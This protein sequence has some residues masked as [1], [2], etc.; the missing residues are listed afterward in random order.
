M[1]HDAAE[2][3]QRAYIAA[4]LDGQADQLDRATESMRSELDHLLTSWSSTAAQQVA[5]HE[6]RIRQMQEDNLAWLRNRAADDG[7]EGAR[8]DVRQVPQD[9]SSLGAPVPPGAG[10]AGPPTDPW[11][12]ELA[13][14]E[15]IRTMPMQ[16]WAE[17]R[18]TLIRTSDGLFG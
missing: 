15:R 11:A 1:S 4:V 6:A 5:A 16:D 13:E 7:D 3:A 9:A 14:A 17:V 18:R 12:A 8:T 10:S 2:R